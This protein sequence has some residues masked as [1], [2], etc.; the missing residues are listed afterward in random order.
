MNGCFIFSACASQRSRAEASELSFSMRLAANMSALYHSALNSTSLP[1]RR[2][3]GMP[4]SCEFIHD[5]GCRWPSVLSRP[6]SA[7]T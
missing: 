5:T 4:P 1:V 3:T 7:S 6:V 2:T